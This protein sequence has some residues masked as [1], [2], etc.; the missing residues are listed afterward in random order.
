MPYTGIISVDGKQSDI[1]E[2]NPYRVAVN[3]VLGITANSDI[4][5]LYV[6][7]SLGYQATYAGKLTIEGQ[8][9]TDPK[10]NHNLAWGAYTELYITPVEDLEWYFEMDVNNSNEKL[11]GVPV[12][13]EA[14]TGITWY[15]P[16]LN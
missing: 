16:A 11:N 4:V 12:N 1:Y 10:V 6:E 5:S 9:T 8:N 13:F 2:K 3:A 15:L 14:T 7:P